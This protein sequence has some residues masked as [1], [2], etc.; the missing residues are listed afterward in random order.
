[1]TD[2]EDQLD[3]PDIDEDDI[4]SDSDL[5]DIFSTMPSPHGLT[6][7]DEEHAKIAGLAAKAL[8]DWAP[9]R[10][11]LYTH[12]AHCQHCGAQYVMPSP[13]IL[14]EYQHRQNGTKK[15][16]TG[17]IPDPRLPLEQEKMP[18]E[19]LAACP[20]CMEISNAH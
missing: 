11:V 7:W 5:D 17:V 6:A 10:R 13:H 16:A 19:P 3:I 15:H 8:G 14:T 18:S 4:F 2:H 9:T 20:A 1:M 12:H